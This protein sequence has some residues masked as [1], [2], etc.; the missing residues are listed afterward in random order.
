MSKEELVVY[1]FIREFHRAR[2]IDLPPSDIILLFA[3]WI[4]LMDTFDKTKIAQ[5]IVFDP[6]NPTK[7]KLAIEADG[8]MSQ[9]NYGAERWRSVP[10]N[11]IVSEGLKRS[12]KFKVEPSQTIIGIMENEMIKSKKTI[13]DCTS[14]EHKGYGLF[15][16]GWFYAHDNNFG[17]GGWL[18]RYAKQ[19]NLDDGPLIV[20]ME[21]DLTQTVNQHGIL[22]YIIHNEKREDVEE[23]S[24]DDKY[25]NIAYDNIDISKEYRLVV[26]VHE[27][28]RNQWVELIECHDL[29]SID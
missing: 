27:S 7:F 9:H 13:D 29:S 23:I 5:G 4:E 11:Y 12:W 14:E 15:T 20:T 25:S 3:I 2:N 18:D 24:T 1:G 8:H 16:G 17:I 6:N 22:K 26:G 10:A 21:L 28:Y 19:F